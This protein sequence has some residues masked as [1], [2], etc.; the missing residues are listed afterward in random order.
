[1]TQCCLDG[2]CPCHCPCNIGSSEAEGSKLA[3]EPLLYRGLR[4]REQ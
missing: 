4:G 3:T 2:D 1:M